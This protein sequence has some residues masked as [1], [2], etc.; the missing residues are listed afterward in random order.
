MKKLIYITSLFLFFGIR[1][2]GQT[3]SPQVLN[4]AGTSYSNAI[5]GIYFTDNIGE[6]FTQTLGN[7]FII[8]QGFLQPDIISAAGPVVSVLKNDV[9]CSDKKDGNIS[10][11]VSNLP[12]N[13]Q[14]N[15]LWNPSSLCP[16]NNCSSLDS[17]NA[18]TYTVMVVITDLS[19][20]STDTVKPAPVTIVDA[21]GPCSVKI[22]NGVTPNGDGENDTW[23][24]EN[25]SEFPDNHVTIY[26]R[27]GA[28]IFETK[29]YDNTTNVWPPKNNNLQGTTYFYIIDLGNGSPAI[30]GWVELITN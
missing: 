27:W 23:V 6:P 2:S 4:S 22:F 5:N 9:S 19:D 12:S 25:I 1:S 15:Y 24:I 13:F 28:K 14:V 30:K 26:N 18:G 17:L 3:I 21:N 11:A 8:T 10:V 16:A 29:K 20:M 7:N